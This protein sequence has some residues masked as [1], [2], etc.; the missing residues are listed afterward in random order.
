MKKAI[1]TVLLFMT[2]SIC[3]GQNPFDKF[4]YKPKIGTL[5]KGKYIEHFDNDSIAQIG[6]V[7][8]NVH[9]GKIAGFVVK[10]V[11]YS[12]AT[13][14]PEIVSRWMSPDPLA[15][16]FPDSSPYTFSNNNPIFFV[17]PTGL[18]AEGVLDDYGVDKDGNIILLRET[19]DNFDRLYAVNDEG[20]E[21]DTNNDGTTNS[22]DSIV[23]N[24]QTI[25]PELAE[26]KESSTNSYHGDK[27]LRDATRGESSQTDLFKIFNFASQNSDVEW[28]LYRLN[29]DGETQFNI[30]TYGNN[31]L[32][33]GGSRFDSSQLVA[34]IH[35]HP[36]IPTTRSE[37]IGSLAGD[38]MNT[39]G[40]INRNGQAP[41][42][43]YI[44]FPN[45]NNIYN[46]NNQNAQPSFIRNTGGSFKKF[47]FGTL[48]TK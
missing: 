44:Y 20:A 4:N 37:E 7:L 29:I 17:D 8:L 26:V 28:S 45:S 22:D 19:D 38:I 41:G 21:Q 13:L 27:N 35:S 39:T 40:F 36:G 1:P 3:F 48:N 12:E 16:E 25:L 47:F 9:T 43:K 15:Q 33:P 10:E 30:G 34:G 2:I 18:A 11:R 5:S 42:L 46:I 32:S 31:S 24:D 6:S 23:V 14:E